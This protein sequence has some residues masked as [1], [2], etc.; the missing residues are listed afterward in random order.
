MGIERTILLLIYLRLSVFIYGS[1]YT[2]RHRYKLYKKIIIA[3]PVKRKHLIL[4]DNVQSIL[5]KINRQCMYIYMNHFCLRRF[6]S[7]AR[8][9]LR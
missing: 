5:N 1:K 3:V 6:V 2:D 7:L 8:E 4:R 9:I